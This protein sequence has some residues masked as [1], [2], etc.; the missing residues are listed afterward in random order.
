MRV[1]E[2]LRSF[3]LKPGI[4]LVHKFRPTFRLKHLFK[5]T[6]VDRPFTERL[7]LPK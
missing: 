7:G 3:L 2:Q 5:G 1:V 6:A 4:N